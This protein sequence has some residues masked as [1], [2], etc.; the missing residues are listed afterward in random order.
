METPWGAAY[1]FQGTVQE[2][3]NSPMYFQDRIY[4][5]I[6]EGSE[7]ME[8][9]SIVRGLVKCADDVLFYSRIFDLYADMMDKILKRFIKKK[10]KLNVK[11]SVFIDTKIKYC[12]KHL[13]KDTYSY[14]PELYKTILNTKDPCTNI[15]WR[16][17]YMC[18]TGWDIRF[19]NSLNTG[20]DLQKQ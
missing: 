12:G 15:G 11:K 5:E 9:N 6:L 7:F 2:W 19:T 20:S 8:P 1:I 16:A 14:E 3:K 18:V 17:F 4:R 13:K 10:V